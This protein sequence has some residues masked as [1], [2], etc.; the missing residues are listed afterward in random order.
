MSENIETL[1]ES[2][3]EFRNRRSA[4]EI[5]PMR[6]PE[7]AE[8]TPEEVADKLAED[9]DKSKIVYFGTNYRKADSEISAEYLWI[10]LAY[11]NKFG[12]KLFIQFTKG[13]YCWAGGYIGSPMEI[14]K[15]QMETASKVKTKKEMQNN[16]S[17]WISL[18]KSLCTSTSIE[19]KE[20]LPAKRVEAVAEEANV[21]KEKSSV[22]VITKPA[23]TRKPI[24]VEGDDLDTQHIL[25]DEEQFFKAFYDKLLVKV[26][27]SPSLIKNYL[28]TMINRE[29]YLLFNNR[30]DDYIIRSAT[31]VN[32]KQY[33]MLNTALLNT[34]GNPI[35]IIVQFY[36]QKA[37][38]PLGYSCHFW[39]ICDSKVTA[40]KYGFSKDDMNKELC[41]VV[42]Y[43]S[44][45]AEMVF[46]ADIEDFDLENEAR[47]DHCLDRSAERG[48]SELYGAM[49][50][51]QVYSSIIQAIRTAIAI[52][53]YDNSY[54]KPIYNRKANKINFAIPYHVSGRFDKA[55]ELGIVVS[56]GNYGLWQIM[57]VLD[58]E[59]VRYDHDCLVPYRAS[60]F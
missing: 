31:S 29:N 37:E 43:D 41:P 45:P 49:S 24:V 57:T 9:F 33:A 2:I 40:I 30:G 8:C 26:G 15:H 13:A 12:E 32:G 34:L 18:N 22:V 17:A 35:K 23:V 39:S 6:C 25:P 54:V 3:G 60:S 11:A 27:W 1:Y 4:C 59:T 42:F 5:L 51:N 19:V 55:P 36:G 7:L 47:I 38:A 58:F 52:S 20:S 44:D 50:D 16:I 56:K 46:S 14:V 48:G 53:K 21:E 28:Y 10:P